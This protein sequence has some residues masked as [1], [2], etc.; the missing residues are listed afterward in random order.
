MRNRRC[1]ILLVICLK[2]LPNFGQ[3]PDICN[4]KGIGDIENAKIIAFNLA[5]IDTVVKEISY[6]LILRCPNGLT[7]LGN[8]DFKGKKNGMWTF[9]RGNSYFGGKFKNNQM[10]G[11]WYDGPMTIKYK[12]G[13]RKSV[14]IIE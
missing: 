4:I 12:R 8:A 6:K 10:T 7:I 2:C 3:T 13:K 1:I 14:I 11:K 9:N 5:K